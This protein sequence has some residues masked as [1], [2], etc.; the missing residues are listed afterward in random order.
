MLSYILLNDYIFLFFSIRAIWLHNQKLALSKLCF[1][2]A[3]INTVDIIFIISDLE[4]LLQTTSDLYRSNFKGLCTLVLKL[5]LLW[6]GSEIWYHLRYTSWCSAWAFRIPELAIFTFE[7][8]VRPN[9][10]K[11]A[12]PRNFSAGSLLANIFISCSL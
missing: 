9:W 11:P 4:F 8:R 7:E 1:C 6:K 10:I 5:L 2:L 3:W 12:M